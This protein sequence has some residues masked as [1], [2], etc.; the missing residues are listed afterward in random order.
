MNGIIISFCDLAF[1]STKN[2]CDGKTARD[3][4]DKCN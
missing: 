4:V 1:V 2:N 3:N